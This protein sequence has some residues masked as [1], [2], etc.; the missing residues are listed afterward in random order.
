MSLV[1]NK[2]HAA[3]V[4]TIVTDVDRNERLYLTMHSNVVANRA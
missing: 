2:S 4:L 3:A 1:L